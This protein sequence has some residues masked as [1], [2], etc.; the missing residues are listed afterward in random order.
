MGN[1]SFSDTAEMKYK[2]KLDFC[3]IKLLNEIFTKLRENKDTI[4]KVKETCLTFEDMKH[5][6]SWHAQKKRT[7]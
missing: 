3:F 1:Y 2:P 4:G 6:F 7:C 5:V